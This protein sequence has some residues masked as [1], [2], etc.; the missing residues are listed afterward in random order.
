M[1]RTAGTAVAADLRRTGTHSSVSGTKGNRLEA[2]RPDWA[3]AH[4]LSTDRQWHP[5][6][7]PL[8]FHRQR[9]VAHA[10]PIGTGQT[11]GRRMPSVSPPLGGPM[12]FVWRAVR[13]G[14]AVEF[15]R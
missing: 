4:A 15:V 7:I 1:I 6:G 11:W 8:A 2:L 12:C 3:A 9:R 5:I 13:R 10:V 14:A